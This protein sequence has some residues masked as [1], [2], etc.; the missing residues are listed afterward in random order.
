MTEL[1]NPQPLLENANGQA[2]WG[3]FYF[4][5]A[6]QSDAVTFDVGSVDS[7]ISTFNHYGSLY[8]IPTTGSREKGY[9]DTTTAFAFS[10]NLSVVTQNSTTVFAFGFIQDP[11]VQFVDTNG[12]AQRRVPYFKTKY[13]TPEDL[14]DDFIGDYMAA[15][16][17]NLGLETKIFIDA[18]SYPHGYYSTLLS[19]ATRLVFASTVLTVGETSDGT[20]DSTDVMMFMKNIGAVSDTT[21]HESLKGTSY[22][23]TEIS[24]THYKKTIHLETANMLLMIYAHARRSG[25]VTLIKEHIPRMNNW[26]EYLIDETLHTAQQE[27]ASLLS[28]YNQTDLAIKGIIAIKAMSVMSNVAG[29]S[30]TYSN[31]ADAYYAQWKSQALS[32][33]NHL[34]IQ[35]RNES[36]WSL[37]ENMFADMWLQTGLISQDIF[38][39]H[40]NFLKTVNITA[41][42]QTFNI[43]ETGIPLDSLRINNV[44]YSSNMFAAGF[45]NTE[46]QRIIMSS[47][48]DHSLDED[49]SVVNNTLT[50]WSASPNLGAAYAPLMLKSVSLPPSRQKSLT[51]PPFSLQRAAPQHRAEHDCPTQLVRKSPTRHRFGSVISIALFTGLFVFLYLTFNQRLRT[52]IHARQTRKQPLDLTELKEQYLNRVSRRRRHNDQTARRR[53]GAGAATPRR[54]RLP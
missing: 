13:S 39:A 7:L 43:A 27:S 3:Q 40:V 35:Y 31:I 23:I 11:A 24:E 33:D 50:M 26:T 20:L 38:T 34:L 41:A 36:S 46:L 12:Q 52:R 42:P 28:I 51:P 49:L 5:T 54:I 6:Q 10:R 14:I 37:G 21:S 30:T 25:N 22:P 1:Q 2:E 17:R 18:A 53:R 9:S 15:S 32:S 45:A 48:Q 19:L 29:Q 16:S 47:V 4:A 8:T 44:T